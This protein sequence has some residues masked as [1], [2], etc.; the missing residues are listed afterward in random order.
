[1]L[2]EVARAKRAGPAQQPLP[3]VRRIRIVSL[4]GT[5]L[6]ATLTVSCSSARRGS[7]QSAATVAGVAATRPVSASEPEPELTTDEIEARAHG[8]INDCNLNGIPDASDIANDYDDDANHNGRID[9]CD[10]DTAFARLA[11]TDDSWKG[12]ASQLDSGYFK[13]RLRYKEGS[14]GVLIRYTVPGKR[15]LVTLGVRDL[16]QSGYDTTL[17]NQGMQVGA[18][19]TFWDRRFHGRNAPPSVYEF[20]LQI[21]PRTYRRRLAWVQ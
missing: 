19:E 8:T 20:R 2:A 5:L 18:I 4:G 10:P 17:V 15:D 6:L 13:V 3:L 11:R 7:D 14:N 16:G 21:G 9:Y 1:M 12:F